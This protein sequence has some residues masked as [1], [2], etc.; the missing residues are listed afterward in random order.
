MAT[1]RVKVTRRQRRSSGRMIQKIGKRGGRTYKYIECSYLTPLWAFEKW[2]NLPKRQYKTFRL[3]Q[4]YDAS[5]WLDNAIQ[6]V[7]NNTWTPP[8]IAKSRE[9]IHAISFSEY[10]TEYVENHH[11]RNGEPLQE[12]TKNKYREYLRLYLIPTFGDRAM[13]AITSDDVQHWYSSFPVRKGGHGASARKH[14]YELLSGIFAQAR[15]KPINSNGDTLIK[16]NPCSFTIPRPQRKK[17]PLIAEP[18]E[19]DTIYNSMPQWLRLSVYLCGVMGLREGECLGLQRKDFDLDTD[20]PMLHIERSA[21]EV[22]QDNH[23]VVILGTTKTE[24]S[25]RD[26]DIPEF[27]LDHIYKHLDAYVEGAPDSPVFTAPRTGGLVKQQTVRNAWYRAI[28]SVPR[29]IGMRFYDLRHTALSKAVEAGASL[30]TVKNMA[31]HAIDTTAFNYQHES[32]SNKQRTLTN[33]NAAFL[34]T[35]RDVTTSDESPLEASLSDVLAALGTVPDAKKREVMAALPSDV[36]A[37]VIS[38][39]VRTS[40]QTDTQES[41]Q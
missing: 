35:Q 34:P 37:K 19:L 12:T 24:T 15:T 33:I 28:Q 29:L 32:Q 27:L 36:L 17:E 1:P 13:T 11:K 2:P 8:Q 9:R 5:V 31:G 16:I 21:K 26:L 20:T 3:E 22:L 40:D 6:S 4:E 7:E 39:A 14:V 38:H 18:E 23:R 10:A 25:V 41:E 30:G